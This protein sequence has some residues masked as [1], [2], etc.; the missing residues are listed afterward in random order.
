MPA[1]D[2]SSLSA[3]AERWRIR[4]SIGFD[5]SLLWQRPMW[6]QLSAAPRCG[7]SCKRSW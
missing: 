4:D 2:E 5:L 7:R 1:K 6:F 3:A